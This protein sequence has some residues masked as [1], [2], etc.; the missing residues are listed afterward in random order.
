MKIFPAIDIKDEKAVR[1]LQGDYDKVTVY[2]DDPSAIAEKFKNQG[3]S[4][5]HVV[6]LDGAK[7]GAA[8]NFHIIKE[9][10]AG[11]GMFVQVGG[12]IRD[13]G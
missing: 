3:A 2:G 11:S 4:Y 5:L 8:A 13:E 9:I 1:L 7:D 12:G 6:D 10:T